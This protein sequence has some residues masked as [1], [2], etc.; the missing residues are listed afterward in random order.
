MPTVLS[1]PPFAVYL[2][3]VGLV[4]VTGV[5]AARYQSRRSV[6]AFG[7]ALSLLL[8]VFLTDRLVESPREEAVRKVQEMAAAVN[9]KDWAGVGS[10]ISDRFDHNGKKKADLLNAAR[11]VPENRPLSVK[12]FDRSA[13]EYL[14]ETRL[15]IE[16]I[17]H[18]GDYPVYA[19]ATFER[20]PDGQYRMVGFDLYDH[21][22]RRKHGP[23][24]QIPGF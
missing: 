21:P 2:G 18:A 24:M 7:V 22:G 11:A 16:F 3:L 17:G 5:V 9:A 12:S 19:D 13:V 6:A 1:D 23:P 20:D 10:H 15:R 4:V 8:A 14:S